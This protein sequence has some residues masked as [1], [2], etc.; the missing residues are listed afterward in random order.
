M[1]TKKELV[2][3]TLIAIKVGTKL[4]K[5]IQRRAKDFSKDVFNQA[6]DT[7]LTSL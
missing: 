3:K 7:I 5:N 1:R 2:D 6:F 4:Q